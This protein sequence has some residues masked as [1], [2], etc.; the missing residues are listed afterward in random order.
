MPKDLPPV[1]ST[2]SKSLETKSD[3][4]SPLDDLLL[5]LIIEKDGLFI[6]NLNADIEKKWA[7]TEYCVA[8]F[9]A[10]IHYH[11]GHYL[12]QTIIEPQLKELQEICDLL[13]RG[14]MT[15]DKDFNFDA[16][17]GDWNKKVEAIIQQIKLRVV[18]Q[19]ELSTNRFVMFPEDDT[20]K[21]SEKSEQNCL[22]M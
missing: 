20:K 16:W 15:K 10:L 21:T 18:K 17:L 6:K 8:R 4:I 22:M 12:Q 2:L 14:V 1:M 11:C 3:T 13:A 19:E 5:Q 9:K 7:N